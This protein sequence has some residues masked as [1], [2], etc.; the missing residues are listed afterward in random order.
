MRQITDEAVLRRIGFEEAWVIHEDMNRQY[1][2]KKEY[3]KRNSVKF[4]ET[5]KYWIFSNQEDAVQFLLTWG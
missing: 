3:F 2:A 1:S 5:C 4:I